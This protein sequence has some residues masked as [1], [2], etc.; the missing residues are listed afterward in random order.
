MFTPGVLPQTPSV[1]PLK[2]VSP[3]RF[4]SLTEC[5]LREVWGAS[6]QQPLLPNSPAARL[7]S[8]I[9][10]L[11]EISGKGLIKN[12]DPVEIQHVWEGLV[13]NTEQEMEES[14]L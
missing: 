8:V 3:S 5:P 2:R 13:R 6:R 11:L 7:G 1:H 12:S 10:R 4:F 9:H 14:W